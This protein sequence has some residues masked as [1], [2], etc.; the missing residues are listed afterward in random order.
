MGVQQITNPNGAFGQTAERGVLELEYLAGAA[1]TGPCV[2][3]TSTDSKIATAATNGTASLAF[4]IARRTIA[5]AATGPVVVMGEVK[6]VPCA[7]AVAAGDI[8][9][10]SVTTAGYVSATATPAAGEALGFAVNASS[11]NT[12]T[13]FVQPSL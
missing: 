10:R 4:G 9:K 8:V 13:V 12:V 2:V 6:L 7:G 3:A 11:S 5:S 1:I